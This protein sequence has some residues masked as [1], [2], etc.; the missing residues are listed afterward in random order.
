LGEQDID[1]FGI[2]PGSRVAQVLVEADYRMKLIGIGLEPAAVPGIPSYFDLLGQPD[3]ARL[4]R[5]IDT[6]R[7]WFTLN[8]E[9]ILASEARDAFELNGSRV[10]VL[11][12]NELLTATGDR[13][14]TGQSDPIN[15]QVAQNFTDHFSALAARD[16]NFADLAGIFDL[17]VAAGL[18][19]AHD[20]PRSTGWAM[21]TFLDPD[22]LVVSLNPP[23]RTV[24]TVMNHRVYRGR[25]IMAVISGGVHVNPMKLVSGD[26]V[27]PDRDRALKVVHAG[28]HRSEPAVWWW[29]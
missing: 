1:I 27:K 23:P 16:V 28:M 21:S 2:H 29:D 5:P 14:H 11:S 17:A 9:S 24:E 3:D 8:Y 4:N 26:T 25:H 22:E 18:L 15:A 10:R 6:L 13:V 19:R 12:E 7:W 20:L